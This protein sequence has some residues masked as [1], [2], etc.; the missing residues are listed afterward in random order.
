MAKTPRATPPLEELIG[1]AIAETE[2]EI[3]DEATNREPDEND[4]DRSLE[5]M[6]TDDGWPTD[7]DGELEEGDEDD[8]DEP[9]DE[10]EGEGDEEPDRTEPDDRDGRIAARDREPD[11]RGRIPSARLREE[12]EGRRVAEAERETERQRVRRLEAEIE[13]L[14]RDREPKAEEP[15]KP[16]IF[17]DPDAW[18]RRQREEIERS[19]TERHVNSSFSETAEEHGEAFTEAFRA[20]TSQNPQ[21]PAA[22]AQVQRIWNAPN[23]GK[24]LMRWHN[25]QQVLREIGGDPQAYERKVAQRLLED[26]DYRR[27]L[28]QALS[29]DARA[30]GRSRVERAIERGTGEVDSKT[31]RRL[32][33]S[34]NSTSGGA[35]H[36]SRDAGPRSDRSTEQ[37]I[38]ESAFE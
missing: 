31:V 1:E 37:E 23:P 17:A 11:R 38:F 36:R 32:P 9:Q 15:E 33:P 24:A 35:A 22:R 4:G 29:G 13:A 20:L 8:E 10:D 18:A 6:D 28:T 7:E 30:A 12:A 25:E 2:Q 19:L 14:K 27:E 16:D 21:D 34:L 5:E 3:F 26:P